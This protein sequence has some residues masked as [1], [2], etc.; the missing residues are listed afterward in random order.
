MATLNFKHMALAL[1][2]LGALGVASSVTQLP[3]IAS[4]Q[5]AA[6]RLG[7]LSRFRA[8]AQDTAVLVDKGVCVSNASAGLKSRRN[9]SW[10]SLYTPLLRTSR[11]IQSPRSGQQASG[12]AFSASDTRWQQR[13]T[14]PAC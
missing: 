14:A 11:T 10:R 6:S 1:G 4:A 5:A 3:G 12:S 9:M 8:I 13:P 2:V 7:D